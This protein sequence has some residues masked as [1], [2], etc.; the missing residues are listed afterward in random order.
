MSL[1]LTAQPVSYG[2]CCERKWEKGV[3][4]MLPSVPAKKQNLN[5]KTKAKMDLFFTKILMESYSFQMFKKVSEK[6][7][8]NQL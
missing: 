2:C 6:P 8:N 3:P 7:S 5:P 1:P 4:D